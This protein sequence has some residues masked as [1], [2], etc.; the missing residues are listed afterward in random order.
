MPA[1][2]LSTVTASGHAAA[3]GVHMIFTVHFDSHWDNPS[4][5][6]ISDS[7]RYYVTVTV[8]VWTPRQ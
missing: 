3:N 1:P 8:T 4:H 5:F 7:A 6:S 2:G